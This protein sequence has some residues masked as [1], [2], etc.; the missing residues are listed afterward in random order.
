[1]PWYFMTR[2]IFAEPFQ[3]FV[4]AWDR[5]ASHN[6]QALQLVGKWEEPSQSWTQSA[7]S[8]TPEAEPL[9]SN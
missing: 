5:G 7:G 1:M 3:P 9:R 4:F 8:G 2:R 6:P